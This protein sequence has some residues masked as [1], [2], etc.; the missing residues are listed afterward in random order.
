MWY[1]RA[2]CTL[3]VST[4]CTCRSSSEPSRHRRVVAARKF[5]VQAGTQALE[6]V[7]RYCL[8]FR[9]TASCGNIAAKMRQLCVCG[10]FI[11]TVFCGKHVARA[12][13]SPCHILATCFGFGRIYGK[14]VAK[15]WQNVATYHCHIFA[16][17]C[18]A[19][20]SLLPK[21]K[22]CGKDVARM[23]QVTC[24]LP[25]GTLARNFPYT[26]HSFTTRNL[27]Q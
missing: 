2:F 25:Q 27:S 11:A 19:P 1:R 9:R 26:C 6:H 3:A 12:W 13:Q 14:Y 10:I 17:F 23:W 22:A 8:A 21:F 7:T 18:L 5:G 20:K 24:P 4:C 16:T 15:K